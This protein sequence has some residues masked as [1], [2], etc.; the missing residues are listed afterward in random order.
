MNPGKKTFRGTIMALILMI[1]GAL[2][3]LSDV[4]AYSWWQQKLGIYP[5]AHQ[6]EAISEGK[7]LFREWC[8][9]CHDKEFL[10]N[11]RRYNDQH[12]LIPDYYQIITFGRKN[13]PSFKSKLDRSERWKIVNF[14]LNP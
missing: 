10:L 14:I 1:S 9:N 13:M 4:P 5:L 7:N 3:I 11:L 12:F 6:K 2:L 8:Q